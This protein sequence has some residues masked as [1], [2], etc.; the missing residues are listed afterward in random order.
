MKLIPLTQN[1]FAIV[2]D[3]DYEYLNQWKWYYDNVGYARRNPGILMHRA[4]LTPKK[5]QDIDHINKNKLDNR[6]INLRV[7]T[8]SQ[9][10]MNRKKHKKG[11]SEYKGVY[12]KTRDRR[13]YAEIC[14]NY[15]KTYLG[16]FKNEIDAAEAYNAAAMK[17]FKNYAQ[18]NIIKRN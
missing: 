11:S 10:S 2:D 7:V 12:W 8:R 4:I 1:K 9:N 16:S 13:W 6:K 17:I 14:M 5:K 15:K 3:N 18:L